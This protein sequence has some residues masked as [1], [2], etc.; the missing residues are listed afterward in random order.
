MKDARLTYMDNLRVLLTVLVVLHHL[1]ITYGAPGGWYYQEYD[2][3]DLDKVSGVVTVALVAV[4]QSFFM[5]LFFF[6]SGYFTPGSYDR[7]GGS[8]F[9][10]RRVLRLGIPLLVYLTVLSPLVRYML[11]T[12]GEGRSLSL[13]GLAELYVQGYY[14]FDVGPL[15][16]TE[17]LLIFAIVYALW[18][19]VARRGS[20]AVDSV[21]GWPR[22]RAVVIYALLVGGLTF[23]VRVWLPVGWVCQPLNLQFPFFPQYVAM[24]FLGAAAYRGRW[25]EQLSAE[26]ARPWGRAVPILLLVL[27]LLFV[28]SGG[29][30]GD[31]SAALGGLHW[32]AFAYA[33]WEQLLCA[34][35]S[36]S[37]LRLF[38]ERH[39][40][41]GALSR[42]MCVGAYATFILHAPVLVGLTLAVKGLV[43][44]PLLKLILLAP[45][46]V[47]LCFTAGSLARRLPGLRAVL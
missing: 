22:H 23:A 10:K 39:N 43:V 38:R 17:T 4:N 46:A 34:A 33:V 5:G 6:L 7:N 9:L 2:T 40:S 29:L 27:L 36:I 16:F 24:L 26:A 3:E 35:M 37:L 11:I 32:Q 15:W 25:P 20:A 41:Q 42:A 28:L 14:G 1:A 30:E 12:I 18:R 47:V 31:V 44:P 8:G 13:L 19:A 45:V 21:V